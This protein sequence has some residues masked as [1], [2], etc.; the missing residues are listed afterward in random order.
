MKRYIVDEVTNTGLIELPDNVK[1]MGTIIWDES[2]DGAIP[3]A[4]LPNSRWLMKSGNNLV[5]DLTRKP[6]VQAADAAVAT[7]KSDKANMRAT[8]AGYN[9]VGNP[10]QTLKDLIEYLGIK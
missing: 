4:M 9:G 1:Y 8:L 2:V 10:N 7:A 3:A 6:A 5:E